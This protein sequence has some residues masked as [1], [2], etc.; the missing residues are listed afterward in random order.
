MKITVKYNGKRFPRVV[1]HR[2]G[3]TTSFHP[4]KRILELEEYDALLLL[5][6]NTRMTHEIW[7]FTIPQVDKPIEIA[8]IDDS[9]S[10]WKD[11]VKNIKKSKNKKIGGE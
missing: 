11:E 2:K 6:S 5:K 4:D 10:S 7:E 1:N 9:G 3:G 8:V